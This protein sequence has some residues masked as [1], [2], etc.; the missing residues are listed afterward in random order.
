MT[1]FGALR[2]TFNLQIAEKK[3]AVSR[4]RHGG[5]SPFDALDFTGQ[6]ADSG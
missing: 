4:I 3:R 1:I 6:S 5:A 2:V